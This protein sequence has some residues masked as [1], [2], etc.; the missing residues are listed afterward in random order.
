VT[1]LWFQC[2]SW[3]GRRRQRVAEPTFVTRLLPPLS[4]ATY[5]GGFQL[6]GVDMLGV[7][8]LTLHFVGSAPTSERLRLLR[9]TPAA[10]CR[11][12][13]SSMTWPSWSL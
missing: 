3:I 10:H 2:T 4:L 1:R 12:V 5:E 8:S 11:M 9:T 6:V 7:D 13:I